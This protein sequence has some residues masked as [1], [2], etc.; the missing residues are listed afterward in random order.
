MTSWRQIPWMTWQQ[1]SVVFLLSIFCLPQTFL[2]IMY[3]TLDFH[4]P[5]FSDYIIIWILHTLHE[6]R[7]EFQY[8]PTY[9]YIF[10]T[11][12]LIWSISHYLLQFTRLE[13]K[14]LCK[15]FLKIEMIFQQIQNWKTIVQT[16]LLCNKKIRCH[17]RF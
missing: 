6:I 2:K 1:K 14:F 8:I 5:V 12:V 16:F 11:R 4:L 7:L 3:L 10:I 17:S 9:L 15:T 13:T